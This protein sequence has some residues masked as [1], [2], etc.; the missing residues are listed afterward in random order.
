M[1][2][3]LS[4]TFLVLCN[5]LLF[6]LSLVKAQDSLG[7]IYNDDPMQRFPIGVTEPSYQFIKAVGGEI[8]KSRVEPPFWWVGMQH[9]ELQILLYD[10]DIQNFEVSIDYPGVELLSVEKVQNPNYLFVNVRIGPGCKAGLF[11]IILTS[12][13]EERAYTY[14]L[15]NREVDKG[16]QQGVDASDLIY[17]IMP[18]RFA[19]GDTGNDSFNHMKQSGIHRGKIHFRHGG[20]L[21]GIM[22][23]L[24]YLKDL[25]VTAIWLNPFLENNEPYDSYHGYA[26]TDS[27]NVDAR[28]GTNEQYVQLVKQCHAR[29]IKVIMDIV[30]NHVGINHWFIR[31][32]PSEDWIHQPKEFTKT[33]YR[34]PTVMDPYASKLDQYE[35]QDAWFDVHM[36]DLNQ[37]NSFVANYLIQNH[38]WWTEYTGQDCYRID[39][40][41]YNDQDFMA[42]WGRRIKTEFPNFT[43]FGETWVHGTPIQAQFTQNNWLRKGYNSNMPGVTDYQMY[44]AFGEALNQEQ[45]W[46]S[47]IMRLYYTLAKDFLYEDPYR[48]VL[49]LD[50]H[51]LSR[52][53]STVGKD[54]IKFKSGISLLMTQ[55]GIPMLYY[56]TEILLTGTGGAFG[57]PGRIDFP[58]GWASD[59]LNKFNEIGRTREEQEAFQ[60]VKTLANY[61]KNTPALQDGKLM[62]FVPL[63]GSNIYVYFR[64]DTAKTVMIVYN[65]SDQKKTVATKRYAERMQGFTKAKNVITGEILDQIDEIEI[66]PHAAIIL[67]LN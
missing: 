47:G 24:D 9:S 48:N 33:T 57:E 6:C 13:S 58:G 28:I 11:P 25:G 4:K 35:L 45:G 22:E 14:E 16:R 42:E 61:R 7:A 60:F 59:T 56:G 31:D 44:Y 51:D 52:F 37:N 5:C 10:Q 2:T 17:L 39:T 67:E 27:Y 65:S 50:N 55:R 3:S 43:F 1:N 64:Y 62:Q 53:F 38:I 12:D 21:I 15:K 23:R 63:N 49:F 30:H 29:G 34:A 41:V 26:I 36:P 66:G 54:L 46:T 40:Y 32:L 8:D 18:D 19:N 20:D